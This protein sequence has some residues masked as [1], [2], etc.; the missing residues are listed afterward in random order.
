[1]KISGIYKFESKVHP[2]RVYIGSSNNING[3]KSS[4]LYSL[5]KKIHHNPKIQAHVNKYGIDDLLFSIVVICDKSELIPV[6]DVI[7]IEQFLIDAYKPWFNVA[8]VAGRPVGHSVSEETRKLWSEQRKG[9]P[10][11]NKGI[12]T[13]KRE[14]WVIDILS[15]S[16]QGQIPWIKGKKDSIDTIIKKSK[17][18]IGK[19]HT[20][21]RKQN[22]LESRLL[23]KLIKEMEEE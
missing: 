2:D 13:G 19:K 18:H 12:K 17:A 10:S 1:M 8:T 14:D 5:K 9:K 15:K 4:H 21:E 7:W 20:W 6:D 22:T 11:W 3:R 23:G 16:H